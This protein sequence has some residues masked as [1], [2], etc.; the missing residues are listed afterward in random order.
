MVKLNY[1]RVMVAA[2]DSPGAFG[3]LEWDSPSLCEHCL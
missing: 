1:G 3:I 2:D